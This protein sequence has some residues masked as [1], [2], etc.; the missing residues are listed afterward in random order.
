[1][2]QVLAEALLP[3]RT[4]ASQGLILPPPGVEPAPRPPQPQPSQHMLS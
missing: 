4:P 2:D 1:M 3:T